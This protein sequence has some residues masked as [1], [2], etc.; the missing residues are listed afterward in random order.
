MKDARNIYEGLDAV[1]QPQIPQQIGSH[2]HSRPQATLLQTCEQHH[3]EFSPMQVGTVE[4]FDEL[5]HQCVT[6][7]CRSAV[8]EKLVRKDRSRTSEDSY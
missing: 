5:P 7:S 8:A 1:D 2:G 3:S 6:Y 4:Q